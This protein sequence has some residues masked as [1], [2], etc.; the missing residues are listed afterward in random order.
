[1][2]SGRQ[3]LVI[4]SIFRHRNNVQHEANTLYIHPLTLSFSPSTESLFFT[5]HLSDSKFSSKLLSSLPSGFYQ[6]EKPYELNLVYKFLKHFIHVIL[7][8]EHKKYS[9]SLQLN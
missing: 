7:F 5:I 6:T 4:N 9:K 1:M 8:Q 3:T 2:V